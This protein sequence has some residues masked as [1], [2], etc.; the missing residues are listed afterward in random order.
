[1]EAIN[2]NCLKKYFEENGELLP[3]L[4]EYINKYGRLP[5]NILPDELDLN[6]LKKVLEF[7]E[8]FFD[9]LKTSELTGNIWKKM[10]ILKPEEYWDIA[11]EE[12]FNNSDIVLDSFEHNMNCFN[13]FSKKQCLNLIEIIVSE[14]SEMNY[15]DFLK[16]FA[17]KEVVDIVIKNQNID[18]LIELFGTGIFDTKM[19][20]YLFEKNVKY[21]QYFPDKYQTEEKWQKAINKI[22]K[23]INCLPKKYSIKTFYQ[24][25][26]KDNIK[27]IKYIPSKFMD[28]E[29][30]QEAYSQNKDLISYFPEELITNNMIQDIIST[31]GNVMSIIKLAQ[32]RGLMT[33]EN[34]KLLISYSLK[35]LSKI[36]KEYYDRNCVE[37]LLKSDKWIGVITSMDLTYFDYDL[38]FMC[39]THSIKMLKRLLPNKHINSLMDEKILQIYL[40]SDYIRL[41]L[42]RDDYLTDEVLRIALEKNSDALSTL[43]EERRTSSRYKIAAEYGYCDANAPAFI[44]N[45]IKQKQL[46]KVIH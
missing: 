8:D 26:F 30:C 40:T 38:L 37:E 14:K 43:E 33:S 24:K 4:A 21:I 35:Y 32:K 1:M 23:L 15:S 34:F 12:I 31:K 28:I 13:Y 36:N 6:L 29:M 18:F 22:P 25:I 20:D 5:E 2:I 3:D 7:D 41:E 16:K 10:I 27:T 44:K 17:I 42:I 11:P 45:Q 46:R 19:C 39:A 9:N